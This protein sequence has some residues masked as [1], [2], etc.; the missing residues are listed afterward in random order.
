MTGVDERKQHNE[1]ERVCKLC[2]NESWKNG[3]ELIDT[4]CRCVGR[5]G[6]E[7]E[8]G[9]GVEGENTRD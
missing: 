8:S 9:T 1:R 3:H 7:R 2:E 6:S 5:R 4:N